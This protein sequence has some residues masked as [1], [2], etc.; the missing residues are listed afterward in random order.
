MAVDGRPFRMDSGSPG[1]TSEVRAMA[2][3]QRSSPNRSTRGSFRAL[4]TT[5]ECQKGAPPVGL[6]PRINPDVAREMAHTKVSRFEKALAIRGGFESRSGKG[7]GSVETICGGRHRRVSQ[8]HREAE[9]RISELD[10]EKG[11]RFSGEGSGTSQETVDEQSRCP[12]THDIPLGQVTALHQMV[13][14]LQS[15]RDPLAK[16][17]N[18]KMDWPKNG[19]A[20]KWL[21]QMDW[22]KLDW[23][24]WATTV[25]G[26]VLDLV[27]R[28]WPIQFGPIHFWIWCVCVSWP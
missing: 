28:L 16:D 26:C 5:Q 2:I 27:G 24:K 25:L 10:T 1:T 4:E 19:L 15:E 12:E 3:G 18:T 9:R 21:G 7:Q 8:V 17:H 22:R 6:K 23:P 20:Q 13:N 14:L 11:T